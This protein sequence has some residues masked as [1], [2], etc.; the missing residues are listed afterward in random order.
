M[1]KKEN[2]PPKVTNAIRMSTFSTV[3]EHSLGMPS[4]SN[5]MG[6][7]NESNTNW[8]RSSQIIPVSRQYG[9]TNKRPKNFTKTQ[10]ITINSLTKVSG[11]KINLQNS[12]ALLYTNNE[13]SEKEFRKTIPFK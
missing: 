10:Q 4:Q 11:C 5:N 9:I 13:K 7:R 8:K 3:I 12:V 2:I 6:G 1:G